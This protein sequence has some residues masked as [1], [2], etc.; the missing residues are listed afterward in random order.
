MVAA[1]IVCCPFFTFPESPA[2]VIHIKP[3]HINSTSAIEPIMPI[4]A[5]IILPITTRISVVP[6]GFG[7]SMAFTPSD[8]VEPPVVGAPEHEVTPAIQVPLAVLQAVSVVA[9]AFT[10][11]EMQQT[12]ATYGVASSPD[13]AVTSSI[14]PSQV[15]SENWQYRVHS[16]FKA[17]SKAAPVGSPGSSTL[18]EKS[19]GGATQPEQEH[20]AD[21][22]AADA[23]F[24]SAKNIIPAE[25]RKN[26]KEKTKSF[27]DII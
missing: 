25:A 10:A 5:F 4:T 23:G 17:A 14:V 21:A 9:A 11:P 6:R 27:F 15:A 8:F 18:T 20:I 3:P 2:A 7:R 1:I 26:I 19:S 22:T 12:P 13:T 16:A 24:K